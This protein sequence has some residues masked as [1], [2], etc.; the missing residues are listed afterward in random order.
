MKILVVKMSSM[1]DV[2][3]ALPALA[4]A[5]QE[6]P[7]TEIDWVVEEGFSDIPVLHPLVD[8][9]IPIAIRRWRKHWLKSFFNGEIGEFIAALR[10]SNYDL[11]IDSQG[12]I[13]SAIVARI[14]R[15]PVGGF[16]R[17][18]ARES[19]AGSTYSQSVDVD[20]SLHA[21]E[22]QRRLFAGLLGYEV[23][24]IT[25]Y[26][27]RIDGVTKFESSTHPSVA[28]SA[29]SIMLLHGTSWD[30]KLW[31][32]TYWRTLCKILLEAGYKVVIPSGNEIERRRAE[33]IADNTSALLLDPMGLKEMMSI[34]STCQGVVSVDSGLGHLAC[35]LDIP[36][37]AL[38]GATDPALTGILGPRQSVIVSDHLPCIP[39]KERNCR[40]GLED[41]SG[42]IYPPCFEQSTPDSVWLA[43]QS[44]ISKASPD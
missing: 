44:Q 10:A 18:S 19:L 5:K 34:M 33:S 12:L 24:G 30:S 7:D 35:A 11:I 3:H 22:R 29:N 23:K 8:K 25:N 42:K 36:S 13:K 21:V 26:G 2:V 31:P 41:Y 20:L 6:N 37:V 9:V 16:S 28:E 1:G 4:D 15:G 27:F 40:Y 17:N 43:L 32:E 39:C 38:Y 14:A